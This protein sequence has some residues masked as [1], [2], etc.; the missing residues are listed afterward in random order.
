[1]LKEAFT[2]HSDDERKLELIVRS[3]F[4]TLV[5]H[6]MMLEM[7]N[8]PTGRLIFEF[9]EVIFNCHWYRLPTS[10]LRYA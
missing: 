9:F 2:R 4:N 6:A 1:M 7:A 8:G 10:G 5:D 3:T